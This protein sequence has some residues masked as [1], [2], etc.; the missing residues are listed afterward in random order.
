MILID[1]ELY[2]II[3][4]FTGVDYEGNFKKDGWYGTD[5]PNYIVSD[6]SILAMLE[7][8]I[9]EIEHLKEKYEDLQEDVK[10]NYEI[11]KFNPYNEYGVSPQDFH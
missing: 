1:Q 9:W 8:L 6:D 10:E 5:E 7:D 4:K 3:N 11:K 2:E